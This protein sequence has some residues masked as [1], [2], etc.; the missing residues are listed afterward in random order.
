MPCRFQ[1]QG[2]GSGEKSWNKLFLFKY[3]YEFAQRYKQ[4][5]NTLC[6]YITKESSL[7]KRGLK[8][9][10]AHTAPRNIK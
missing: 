2:L 1:P 3:R 10:K 8:E 7:P 4:G 9:N 6:R 5:A